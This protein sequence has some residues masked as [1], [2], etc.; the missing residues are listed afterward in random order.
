[1]NRDQ[2]LVRREHQPRAARR[3]R[4]RRASTG[5]DLFIGLSGPRGHRRRGAG[6]DGPRRDRLRDGQPGAR[7]H[8]RGGRARTRASWPPAAPTTRTRSTTC[9]LPRHLPRRARRPR[10]A[11]I[12]E[13]MKLAAAAA[14]A[15][16]VPDDELRE[17]YIIPS[18]F[19]RDVA[20]A[21]AAAVAEEARAR[22]GAV[23][24]E[25]GFAAG[26]ELRPRRPEPGPRRRTARRRQGPAAVIRARRRMRSCRP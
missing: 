17:D 8:A 3:R 15:A 20:P 7:D 22:G 4:R 14:I 5:A 11:Q 16:I 6:A 25:V 9:S 12:T 10:A 26:D 18:V 2:A 21:V 24:N 1:M 19:N 13:E 23:G